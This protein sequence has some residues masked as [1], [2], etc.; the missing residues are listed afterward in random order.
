MVSDDSVYS[1]SSLPT[2]IAYDIM[3]ENPGQPQGYGIVTD[4]DGNI[5]FQPFGPNGGVYSY[6]FAS[7]YKSNVYSGKG[8]L[9][10]G[11]RSS[12]I[13]MYGFVGLCVAIASYSMW[14]LLIML[15][16]SFGESELGNRGYITP[17]YGPTGYG[18]SGINGW[19]TGYLLARLV[20]KQRTWASLG[21]VS[22]LTNYTLQWWQGKQVSHKCH[23]TTMSQGFIAGLTLEHFGP[24]QKPWKF[25]RKHIGKFVLAVEVGFLALG[26]YLE[27]I[28]PDP[29]GYTV[30]R[31]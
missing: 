27:T 16:L 30:R 4:D 29:S 28:W 3:V 25:I 20:S 22:V 19:L 18:I 12:I 31:V 26:P 7:F 6:P 17:L 8:K 13:G 14:D 15:T 10:E 24:K 9:N 1:E 11:I 5:W 23:F 2:T 21:G